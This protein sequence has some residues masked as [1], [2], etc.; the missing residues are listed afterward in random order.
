MFAYI[1]KIANVHISI[2]GVIFL[3][4]HEDTFS[5]AE[6]LQRNCKDVFVMFT[7]FT[8]I[9]CANRCFGNNCTLLS[10]PQMCICSFWTQN[11]K[12]CALTILKI[13]AN[14]VRAFETKVINKTYNTMTIFRILSLLEHT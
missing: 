12:K 9:R 14:R 11:Q 6:I 4:L 8:R 5:L 2:L 10:K 13:F 7:T 1:F 3:N